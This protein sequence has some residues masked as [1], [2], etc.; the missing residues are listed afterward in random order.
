MKQSPSR[1]TFVKTTAVIGAGYWAAGGVAPRESRSAI[2]RIQFACIGISGKGRSD[3]EDASKAGD[4]VAVTDI[5]DE[6]MA[7]ET[8]R[9]PDAAKF[10]DFREMM[11]KMGDKIDAVTV[12]TPD[13][14]HAVAAAA[15]MKAGKACF[16]QKPL[17]RTIWEARRLSD[18]ATEAGVA[19]QMG[20]QGSERSGLREA[21]ARIKSGFL[22][23]VQEVHVWTNRPV[24][25]Q[26]IP[27]PK[28][29]EPPTHI[30]WNEF[31]GPGEFRPYDAAYH[32]FKWRGFWDFGTGALGDMACHTMN[33][34]F[35]GCELVNPIAVKATTSGHNRETFPGWSVIE[36]DFGPT[37]SRPALKV[38]WYDGGKKPDSAVLAGKWTNGNGMQEFSEIK[39]SGS[40]V[41]GEKGKIFSPDDYGAE[42]YWQGD[43]TPT[44]VEFERSPGHFREWVNAIKGGKPAWS[45]FQNYAGKLTEVI[46]LGNLAVWAAGE[47]K[48]DGSPVESPKLEWDQANLKVKGTDA[49]DSLIKPKYREGYDL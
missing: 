43:V 1:R 46:L 19:T 20:N 2:E 45:N 27:R 22:G 34:P 30:H 29:G 39:N 25:P 15:A 26:G 12:S 4:V 35:A 23:K 40:L 14:T 47:S 31:I 28:G 33:M 13:H 48:A 37:A 21:A 24:W 3:S 5:D 18:I 8:E 44:D 49:Y 17:T 7:K 6:T 9:F 36:F 42:Y 38:F 41:I 11:A 32:P 10:H 16:C